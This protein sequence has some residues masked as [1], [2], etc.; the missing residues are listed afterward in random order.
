MNPDLIESLATRLEQGEKI[1]SDEFISVRHWQAL[2]PVNQAVNDMQANALRKVGQALQAHH[3]QHYAQAAVSTQLQLN[4]KEIHYG[5]LNLEKL[6]LDS[7]KEGRKEQVAQNQIL[8][9]RYDNIKVLNKRSEEKRVAHS[10]APTVVG[11][12]RGGP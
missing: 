4:N 1:V 8:L 6:L 3:E 9:Q 11:T 5:V 2:S 7:K 12:E 10:V